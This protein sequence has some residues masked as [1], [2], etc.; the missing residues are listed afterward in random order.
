MY[1]PIYLQPFPSN[2]TRNF[3]RSPFQHN[4]AHFGLPRYAPGT[5]EMNSHDWKDDSTLVRCLAAYTHLSSTISE[6]GVTPS[7]FPE[8]V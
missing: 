1:L 3:K 2:P 5:I 4:F 6:Q 8:D 7:E